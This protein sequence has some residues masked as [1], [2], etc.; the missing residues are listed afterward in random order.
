MEGIDSAVSRVVGYTPPRRIQIVIDD[1]YSISNGSAWPFLDRPALV[2]WATP[3]SPR[4]DVGNYVSWAD[5]L[6]SHE[7]AHLAHLTGRRETRRSLWNLLPV[8]GPIRKSPGSPRDTRRTSKES[9]RVRADRTAWR[10]TILRQWAIEGRF[11]PYE[12][13]NAY[14]GLYG[15]DFAYVA[16]SAFIEWLTLRRGDSSLVDLWRRLTAKADRG[17]DEAFTGV[18]GEPAGVLYGRFTAELTANAIEMRRALMAQPPDSGR[19][20]QHLP[21]NGIRRSRHAAEC[22]LVH[23][24][25]PGVIWSTVPEPDTA[26]TGAVETTEDVPAIRSFR[27]QGNPRT[28]RRSRPAYRARDSSATAAARLARRRGDGRPPTFSSGIPNGGAQRTARKCRE[29]PARRRT[30]AGL[31]ARGRCDLGVDGSAR[32]RSPRE[33]RRARSTG[34]DS[35]PTAGRFSSRFMT[36]ADGG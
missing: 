32:T 29:D 27:R 34:R 13:L 1:P 20:I 12:Q 8:L 23:S 36:A 33:Q 15:G 7:F 5:M 25:P 9:S 17:F 10:P 16:G 35:R 2:F 31:D 11:P 28:C 22:A 19:V 24:A 6:A 30:A 14:G 3:P 21:G 4:E 26:R 18:Y